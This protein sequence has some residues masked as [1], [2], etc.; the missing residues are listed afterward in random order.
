[1]FI[2]E[3]EI[4]GHLTTDWDYLYEDFTHPPTVEGNVLQIFVKDLGLLKFHK[5]DSSG[6][7]MVRKIKFRD[8][9]SA[10]CI[11][12]AIEEAQSTR[13]QQKLVKQASMKLSRSQSSL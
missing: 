11:L 4:L 2:K 1:M 5:K 8:A 3:V 13:Q 6:Q 12:Q 10:K 9:D 7:E